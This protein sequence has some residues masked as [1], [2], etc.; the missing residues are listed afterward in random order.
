MNI[1]TK[2]SINERKDKNGTLITWEINSLLINFTVPI[3]LFMKAANAIAKVSHTVAKNQ[4]FQIM[5]LL[6]LTKSSTK[7]VPIKIAIVMYMKE[8]D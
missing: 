5:G 7:R 3:S 6:N 4:S 1:A 2:L 8:I